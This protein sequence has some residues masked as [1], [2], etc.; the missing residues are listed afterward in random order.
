MGFKATATGSSRRNRDTRTVQDNEFDLG[1]KIKPLKS[2]AAL[3][4][5]FSGL[6]LHSS[7]PTPAEASRTADVGVGDRTRLPDRRSAPPGEFS[8][9]GRHPSA[10]GTDRMGADRPFSPYRA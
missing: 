6:Q 2:F 9:I 4:G 3:V 8:V 10:K 7:H 1:G 5:D